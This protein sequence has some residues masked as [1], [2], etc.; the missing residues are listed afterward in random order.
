MEPQWSDTGATLERHWSDTGATLER[1]WSDTGARG[2]GSHV[3]VAH[4]NLSF[5]TCTPQKNS[6]KTIGVQFQGELVK[7]GWAR[8]MGGHQSHGSLPT[9][10]P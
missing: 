5:V 3:K 10:P 2:P 9:P 7:G 6:T 4:G 1:Q 8:G